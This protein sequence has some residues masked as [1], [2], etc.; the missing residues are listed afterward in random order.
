MGQTATPEDTQPLL[1][2]RDAAEQL[3]VSLKTIYREIDRGELPALH[4]GRQI[5]IDPADLRDYLERGG[6]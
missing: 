3:A 1:T 5:R 4:A 6:A 2:P